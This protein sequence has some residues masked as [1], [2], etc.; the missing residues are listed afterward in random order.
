MTNNPKG[1]LIFDLDGT[2][3]KTES[4]TVPA[5]QSTFKKYSL[6]AP[7]E[8]EI[9]SYFGKPSKTYHDW[10]RSLCPSTTADEIIAA[11]DVLELNLIDERGLLYPQII[12]TLDQLNSLVNQIAL[13]TNGPK[14]YVER[15]INAMGLIKY[16]DY[17]RFHRGENDHKIFKVRE[18]LYR[19]EMRPA[20]VIG[21]RQDDISAAHQNG[22]LSIG[23][24]YG[25]GTM[26]ELSA[27]HAIAQSPSALPYLV[28]SLMENH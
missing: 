21:D 19:L 12:K 23:V 5:V 20:I 11:I 4:V 14:D 13:C 18:I 24:S 27:A 16:F 25:Y 9:C 3:F 26:E 7:G 1:L 15:V 6:P 2:L 8:N 10:L 28:L 17:V 22:I